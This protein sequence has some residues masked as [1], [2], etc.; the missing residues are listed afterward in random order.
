MRITVDPA[1]ARQTTRN[2]YLIRFAFGGL[3]AVL[4]GVIGTAYGPE[5]GGLFLAFPSIS[6]ASLT[7]IQRKDG[8]NA[9]GVDALGAVLGSIGLIG[10]GV[11]VWALASRTSAWLTL[12]VATAVWLLIGCGLWSA[13][14]WA[15]HHRARRSSG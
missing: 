14:L 10:F 11:V 3:V 1:K 6:S 8:K 7:L 12:I 13:S 9:A 15:R 5:I 2:E 4:A